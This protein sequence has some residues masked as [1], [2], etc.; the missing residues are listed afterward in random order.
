V[1]CLYLAERGRR[2]VAKSPRWEKGEGG[3]KG[4]LADAL[5]MGNARERGGRILFKGS[6]CEETGNVVGRYLARRERGENEGNP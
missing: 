3:K 6:S 2:G 1:K 5:R 4:R